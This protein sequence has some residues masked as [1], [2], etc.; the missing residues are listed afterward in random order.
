MQAQPNYEQRTFA[1][2]APVVERMEFIRRVY[3]LF[4]MGIFAGSRSRD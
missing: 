1:A 3:S 4:L 2:E